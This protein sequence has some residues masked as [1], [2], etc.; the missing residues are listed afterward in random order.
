MPVHWGWLVRHGGPCSCRKVPSNTRS[1]GSYKTTN[2]LGRLTNNRI[3]RTQNTTYTSQ[4]Q[5]LG[6]MGPT[7]LDTLQS[8]Q[9]T[10]SRSLGSYTS[11][12]ETKKQ[13]MWVIHYNIPVR[14]QHKISPLSPTSSD[15]QS[16]NRSHES[17]IIRLTNNRSHGSYT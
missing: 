4:K 12:T 8:K 7:I 5:T 17:Y 10:N 16:N 2:R 6:P 13:V 1:C 11:Q 3:C 15:S 9:I 14:N